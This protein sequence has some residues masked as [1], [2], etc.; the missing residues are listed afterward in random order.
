M[1]SKKIPKKPAISPPKD[2]AS[3]KDTLYIDVDDEI[4]SVI[5]KVTTSKNR[6]IA[7][8]LPK[9][10][11][12]FQSI[13]NMK[14][15]KKAAQSASKNMVLITSDPAVMPIAAVAGLHVAKTPSSKP[16]IPEIPSLQED[17]AQN[18]TVLIDE[19]DQESSQSSDGSLSQANE[20]D[21]ATSATKPGAEYGITDDKDVIELDNTIDDEP[22]APDTKNQKTKKNRKKIVK[23]P[24][25]SSFSVRLALG[26]ALI[27]L[28]IVLWVVGFIILPKATITLNTDTQSV[29]INTVVTARVGAAELD[30]ENNILP[31]KR[32]QVEKIDSVTV[33]ATGEK[34][35]GEKATGIMNLTNCIN[36]GEDKIIPA[37]TAFSSGNITFVT[38]EAV[39]LDFAI[40]AGSNCVSDDFGRDE[41]VPVVATQAGPDYNVSAKAYNS[42][43]SGIQAFG[44]QMT[45]GTTQII[46]VVSQADVDQAK[47]QLQDTSKTAALDELKKLVSDSNVRPI[48]E[49]LTESAPNYD[50]SPAVDVEASEVTVKSIVNY[51]LI[52]ASNEDISAILDSVI[53]KSLESTDAENAQ[54]KNI[55]ENGL[56]SMIFK[57][58]EQTDEANQKYTFETVGSVGPDINENTIKDSVVGR[59]RGEI[60]KQLEAIDGVRSVSVEYS[61]AW[62]TTTPKSAD[63][64]EVIFNEAE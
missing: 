50:I 35:V 10:A 38:T 57:L 37:G 36:D 13:V 14:L 27:L 15:L 26:G 56:D 5:D 34:N 31:A 32:S 55:R 20:S 9:R 1:T 64:I 25:F 16:Y 42:S 12:V 30:L 49:S 54:D 21:T 23:I 44:S 48:D 60:E 17:L 62:I 51:A 24:D 61:P 11:T 47:Q 39:T 59:K 19:E 58:L 4:T 41:D 40:F 29:P 43:I 52:G 3:A 28:L 2:N 33:P 53:K 8:V 45:G 18:E 7:V 22:L 6:I 46:K 63:K